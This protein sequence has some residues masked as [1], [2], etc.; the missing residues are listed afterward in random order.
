MPHFRNG[1][2]KHLD[3]TEDEWWAAQAD[4]FYDDF[5]IEEVEDRTPGL[6]YPSEAPEGEPFEDTW[7]PGIADYDRFNRPSWITDQEDTK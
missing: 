4:Y 1:Y 6:V 2:D 3:V 5:N 7:L